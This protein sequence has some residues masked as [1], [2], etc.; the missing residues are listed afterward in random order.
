MLFTNDALIE[1]ITNAVTKDVLAS[2]QDAVKSEISADT[3]KTNA[4]KNVASCLE[5]SLVD[6]VKKSCAT[7]ME[8]SRY[9][10]SG[11]AENSVRALTLN[12][13]DINQISNGCMT[14]DAKKKKSIKPILKGEKNRLPPYHSGTPHHSIGTRYYVWT[15]KDTRV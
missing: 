3:N 11:A 10:H 8:R 14:K 6:I 5:N 4:L 9:S 12:E 13:H 15:K 7:A 1:E 2:L